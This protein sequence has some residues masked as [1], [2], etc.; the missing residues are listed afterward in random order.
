MIPPSIFV[1]GHPHPPK[2]YITEEVWQLMLITRNVFIIIIV[3]ER[4]RENGRIRGK[5]LEAG[6]FNNYQRVCLV[7]SFDSGNRK[8]QLTKKD[9]VGGLL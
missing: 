1:S 3:R 5:V 2:E 4:E 8:G 7:K 9:G 6:V